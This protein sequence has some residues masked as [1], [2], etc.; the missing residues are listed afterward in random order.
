MDQKSTDF[1]KC[2]NSLESKGNQFE[3]ILVCW[4]HTPRI[5][6]TFAAISTLHAWSKVS[7][8]PL[9]MLNLK[10]TLTWLLSKVSSFFLYSTIPGWYKAIVEMDLFVSLFVRVVTVLKM[11]NLQLGVAWYRFKVKQ[12]SRQLD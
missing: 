10:G 6:H 4:A 12:R 1:S 5:D 9:F 7:K 3:Y 8:V 11:T 2:L